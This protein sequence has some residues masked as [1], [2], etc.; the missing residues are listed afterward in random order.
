L[1]ALVRAERTPLGITEIARR[2]SLPE[3]ALSKCFQR[4]AHQ[5]ILES[6]RG[7]GGGYRLSLPA[8]KIT[9]KAVIEALEGQDIRRGRCLLEERD[10]SSG[11]SCAL[12]AA[13]VEADARMK[14]VLSTLTL[15]DLKKRPISAL[16]V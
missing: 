15:A 12:H 5:G 13:A 10:C 14:K 11:G 6:Q 8:E 16:G 7:P 1:S 4:L 9:L 2:H 3:A